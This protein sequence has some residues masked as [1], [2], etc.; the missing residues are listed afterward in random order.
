M[1]KK[2]A[3]LSLVA[4]PIFSLATTFNSFSATSLN[5]SQESKKIKTKTVAAA[6]IDFLLGNPKTADKMNPTQQIALGLI[7]DLLETQGQREHELDLATAGRDQLIINTTD[8]RQAQ[9]VKDQS[10]NLYL[11][12]EGVIY[13]L[14]QEL[15]NQARNIPTISRTTLPLY[16]LKK[17]KRKYNSSYSNN[18]QALF[19][20]KWHQDLNNDGFIG[21]SEYKQI[22]RTFYKDEDFYIA[23][24]YAIKNK[25]KGNLELKIFENYSGRLMLNKEWRAISPPKGSGG[26]IKF[27]RI[28]AESFPVGV[29]LIQ[30]NLIKD[31]S[32]TVS[33]ESEK[34]EIIQR[35]PSF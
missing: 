19:S 18:I 10:G 15:V 31:D 30:A 17:L 5:Y 24:V 1:I 14:A 7:G 2:R 13:P 9:L 4:I 21:F 29:Y 8:G 6:V 11:V 20:Y 3:L 28:Y 16:D 27:E 23:I 35:T 34:F 22:K 12:F 25:F 32:K 26:R 33:S